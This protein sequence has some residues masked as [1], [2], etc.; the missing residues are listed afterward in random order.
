MR[1]VG[2]DHYFALSGWVD[3][4]T[5]LVLPH[6]LKEHWRIEHVDFVNEGAKEP[7]DLETDLLVQLQ[8]LLV[9]KVLQLGAFQVYYY[10]LLVHSVFVD[11][12]LA[13]WELHAPGVL[14][15]FD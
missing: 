7:L 8:H 6:V 15:F 4:L 9:C 5:Q 13:V 1:V 14:Q 11:K 3:A 10:Y 2:R 12:L